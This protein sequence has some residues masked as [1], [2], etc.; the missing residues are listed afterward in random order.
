[1]SQARK[2][3]DAEHKAGNTLNKDIILK[4]IRQTIKDCKRASLLLDF[5]EKLSMEELI[6]LSEGWDYNVALEV[7]KEEGFEKG[8]EKGIELCVEKGITQRDS[9]IL[10]LM[11]QGYTSEQLKNLL[12]SGKKQ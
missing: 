8:V 10:Q 12:L 2:Y 6:M 3:E 1:M 9:E 5:W 11:Q 4:I 7:Y